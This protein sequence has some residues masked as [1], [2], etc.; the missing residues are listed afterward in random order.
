DDPVLFEGLTPTLQFSSVPAWGSFDNLS[1]VVRGV[2]FGDFAVAVFIRAWIGWWNK[3]YWDAPKSGLALNGLFTTDVTTGGIDETASD[4]TAYLV[5]VN[6]EPPLLAG[7]DSLPAELAA[8]AV[9]IVT[10][11]R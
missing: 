3:P 5:P 9:A 2:R 10:V 6:Y 8:N 11:H 4:I 1:G 7:A